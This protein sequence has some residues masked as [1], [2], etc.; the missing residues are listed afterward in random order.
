L[1]NLS[2]IVRQLK[3]ERDRVQQQLSG[4]NA[5]LAA[6]A[7]V[8]AGNARTNPRRKV[9][10]KGRARIAAAQRA[11]GAKVKGPQKVV[12]IARSSKIGK[13]TDVSIASPQNRIGSTGRGGQRSSGGRKRPEG[14]NSVYNQYQLSLIHPQLKVGIANQRHPFSPAAILLSTIQQRK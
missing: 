6:F 9:S 8:Y 11:R 13:P 1:A 5:A 3:R 14:G 12:P 4:L 2:K 10:A 7:G